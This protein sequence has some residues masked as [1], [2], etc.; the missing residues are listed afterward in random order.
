MLFHYVLLG[1]I[2][3]PFCAIIKDVD[4]IIHIVDSLITKNVDND[5]LCFRFLIPHSLPFPMLQLI[6]EIL[7]S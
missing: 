1:N 3:I 4:C 2:S 6:K 5:E 7:C